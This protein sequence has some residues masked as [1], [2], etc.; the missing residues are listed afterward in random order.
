MGRGELVALLDAAPGALRTLRGTVRRWTHVGRARTASERANDARGGEP[1][2]L[3]IAWDG[4]GGMPPETTESESHVWYA[5]PNRWRVEGD[6]TTLYLSDGDQRWEGFTSF[7]TERGGQGEV[8]GLADSP[9]LADWLLPGAL[10]GAYRFDEVTEVEAFGR[11]CLAATSKTRPTGP[12]GTM[13][14]TTMLAHAGYGGDE[15][16]FVVDAEHGF[17][18][19]RT[20]LVDGEP[21]AVTE[22]IQLV[23]DEPIDPGLFRVPA[24]TTVQTLAEERARMLRDAGAD[25]AAVDLADDA[26]VSRA[27][28]GARRLAPPG[29]VPLAERARHF[30]PWGPPPDD[31]AAAEAAIHAAFRA[32]AEAS[33][34][35]RDL[36]NVQAGEGLVEPLTLAGRRAP[37][38]APGNIAFAVDALRFVCPDEAVVW[39]SLEIGGERSP[40][41]RER[42]GRAVRD[43]GRWLIERGTIAELLAFAGARVPPP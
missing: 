37:G 43:G 38:A 28:A 4:S 6:D 40:L 15:H 14:V 17:V 35:G 19:R 34:D 39:F 31:E 18:V 12:P 24:G 7:V 13:G 16:R 32:C 27:M 26:A 8:P 25:P 2:E 23:V 10:L 33:A 20:A 36:V 22:L 11:R 21:W 29:G 30:V 5:A 3:L 1:A 9:P 41:V 42:R